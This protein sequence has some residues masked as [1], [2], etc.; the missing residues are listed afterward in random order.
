M[1]KAFRDN[2]LV[3]TRGDT[4][5]FDIL[6]MGHEIVPE[7]QVIFTVKQDIT[8]EIPI[9]QKT[10]NMGE[11]ILNPEDT[12]ELPCGNYVYDIE[13]TT[14]EGCVYTPIQSVFTIVRGVTE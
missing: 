6:I 5:I 9:I 8:D 1:F 7:D 12:E 10:G 13:I 11:F 14:Q 2:K 3:L 4:A